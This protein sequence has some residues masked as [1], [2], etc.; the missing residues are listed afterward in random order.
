MKCKLFLLQIILIL[1]ALVSCNNSVDDVFDVVDASSTPLT[2]EFIEKGEMT[3]TSELGVL[4]MKYS[5]DGGKTFTKAEFKGRLG[6]YTCTIEVSVGDKISLYSLKGSSPL[7]KIGCTADCYVYGNIMSLVY[8]EDF[9]G[10]DTVPALAFIELFYENNHIRN[11][12]TKPLILPATN[13]GASCYSLMFAYSSIQIAP[14]LPATTLSERCYEAMFKCS[15]LQAAP[16]LPAT[17]LAELCYFEM[18][19]GCEYLTSVPEQLPAETLVDG[20]YQ[21]MFDGC[22]KITT[23][24]VLYGKILV[25]NCYRFM[26]RNCKNLNSIT[27]LAIDKD[28]PTID[29]FTKDWVKN[30]SDSG[31]FIKSADA[32]VGLWLFDGP[33]CVPSGWIVESQ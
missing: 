19:S 32:Y 4:E 9:K 30:V 16:Q 2:L 33:S 20:C 17:E 15:D 7:L 28:G 21:Q 5:K 27:C 24:P 12:A 25:D 31:K 23:A 10:K 29:A 13:L 14:E 1:V 3:L 26:F 22:G 6:K 18:F 11:H 8:S